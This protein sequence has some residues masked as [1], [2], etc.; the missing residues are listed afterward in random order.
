[1]SN[2]DDEFKRSLLLLSKLLNDRLDKNN[3]KKH[4]SRQ[5]NDEERKLGS[6]KLLNIYLEENNIDTEF[7]KVL[8]NIQ[9]LRSKGVAH[10]EQSGYQEALITILGEK[11]KIQLITDMIFTINNFLRC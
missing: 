7:A 5:L 2:E 1:L 3:I 6:I 11:T 9:L 8:E 4:I 10:T